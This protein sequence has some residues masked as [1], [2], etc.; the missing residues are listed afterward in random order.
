MLIFNLPAPSCTTTDADDGEGSHSTWRS[1]SKHKRKLVQ[2][3]VSKI[4]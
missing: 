4:V 1:W 2:I 3:N